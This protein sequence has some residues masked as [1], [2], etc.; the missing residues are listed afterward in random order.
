[1][2]QPHP[3][4]FTKIQQSR[5]NSQTWLRP[6][7]Y[8][9]SMTLLGCPQQAVVLYFIYC[10]TV[11]HLFYMYSAFWHFTTF[12]GFFHCTSNRCKKELRIRSA[13]GILDLAVELRSP[14]PSRPCHNG[15]GVARSKLRK[16]IENNL[17]A[18]IQR[19]VCSKISMCTKSA[20]TFKPGF[21]LDKSICWAH[22]WWHLDCH[23]TGKHSY[24]CPIF[25]RVSLEFSKSTSGK[26]KRFLDWPASQHESTW[27][28]CFQIIRCWHC[29]HQRANAA[30]D[31][32]AVFDSVL[33]E[34][35]KSPSLADTT[36]STFSKIISKA[37]LLG[38]ISSKIC[39]EKL[40]FY[41]SMAPCLL[42][43]VVAQPRGNRDNDK[44]FSTQRQINT[45]RTD[46]C[47]WLLHLMSST[48]KLILKEAVTT[49]DW[50]RVAACSVISS[51]CTCD[52]DA[53]NS[54]NL[55]QRE[56]HSYWKVLHV[57][58]T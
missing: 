12:W 15:D 58:Q 3:K 48:S 8:K 57:S 28:P 47:A 37:L 6:N 26:G 44:T 42:K 45:A 33:C 35:I 32:K 53:A 55:Y 40:V 38:W 13:S 43:R 54:I 30:V 4:I 31:T 34:R 29:F 18:I 56:L 22:H 52:Q 24:S 46:N 16:F 23:H 1:M 19:L 14:R 51:M 11:I 41:C 5:S 50:G 2:K 21:S 9:A 25:V 36:L 20:S 27:D 39:C 17:C 10:S 49:W 7:K